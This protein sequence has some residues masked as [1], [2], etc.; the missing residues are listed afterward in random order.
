MDEILFTKQEIKSIVE[1]AKSFQINF[2]PQLI[3]VGF[4][5]NHTSILRISPINKLIL[6]RG[7]V[8]TGFDHIHSRHDFFS[9]E[10]FFNKDGKSDRPTK[11]PTKILPIIDYVEISDVVF[12]PENLSSKNNRP[13]DFDVYDGVIELNNHLT[14][15][16][17]LILYKGTKIIHTLHAIDDKKKKTTKTDYAR[18]ALQ[19]EHNK[20]S[21]IY[22]IAIPYFNFQRKLIF[23]IIIYNNPAQNKTEFVIQSHDEQGECKNI[24]K[25]YEK[26]YEKFPSL[27][28][29]KITWQNRNLSIIEQYFNSI[30]NQEK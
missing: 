12:K 24:Y 14:G 27:T 17:R 13:N 10:F 11:F 8:Y 18:G 19:V 9:T 1:N 4:G 3:P 15:K 21:D 23:L 25:I 6:A 28:H 29:E 22:K 30:E 5:Q 2:P 26:S 16:Y 7:N 20:N